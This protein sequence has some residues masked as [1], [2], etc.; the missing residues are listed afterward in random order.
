MKNKL[1]NAFINFN[2]ENIEAYTPKYAVDIIIPYLPKNRIIWCPFSKDNHNFVNYLKEK[3][4][5]IKNT[6]YDPITK[7]GDDFLTY[8][9]DFNFDM[10]LDNP[11]FKNKSKYV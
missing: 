9:P 6:H 2:K 11:P 10:I 8:E 3:G 1:P 4:Y 5:Y 7:E